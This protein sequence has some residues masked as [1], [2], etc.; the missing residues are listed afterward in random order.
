M[1]FRNARRSRAAY[2]T[3]YDYEK[4]GAPFR[5]GAHW[6]FDR[7]SGLQTQSA[8]YIR[9]AE[10]GPGTS[11]FRSEHAFARRHRAAR[12]P[13]VHARRQTDGIFD[14]NGGRG[15]ADVA[16]QIRRDRPRSA[17]TSCI[18]RSFRMLRGAATAAFTTRATMRRRRR[19]KRYPL[20]GVQKVWFH[21]LGT[22]QSSDRLVFASTVHPG[23]VRRR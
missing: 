14:A 7:N 21:R 17:P 3:L 1:R 12:R 4:I 18:G 2:R 11:V 15:L 6:F 10:I 8:L 13:F 22:P 16:R 20:L 5:E 23:S 9:N 19:I